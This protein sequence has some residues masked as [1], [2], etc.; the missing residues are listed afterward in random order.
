MR[1]CAIIL[2][3][4]LRGVRGLAPQDDG[5]LL[6]AATTLWVLCPGREAACNAASQNRDRNINRIRN[7]PGSAAHRFALRRVRGTQGRFFDS[8]VRQPLQ[9]ARLLHSRMRIRSRASR[10]VIL[11]HRA[12]VM[13]GMER[14]KAQRM[15]VRFLCEK[16]ARRLAALHMRRFWARGAFF[17]DR[18]GVSA[19]DPATFAAFILSASSH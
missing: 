15:S 4:V 7:G 8:I 5:A 11:H 6:F 10:E 13:R 19:S 3:A 2:A 17:R 12:P 14:R 9:F 16:E 18:T 1:G